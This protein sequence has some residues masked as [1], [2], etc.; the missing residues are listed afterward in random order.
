MEPLKMH[1]RF[2]AAALA[3]AAVVVMPEQAR[4]QLAAPAASPP[5]EAGKRADALYKQGVRLY[6]EKKWA[7]AEAAFREAWALNPTFDVAYNLGSAEY[8]LGKHRDAAEHLALAVRSWPLL[9]A[10]SILR[11]T[12]QQ[13]LD[14]CRAQVG[15]LTVTV[16]VARAE[17]LIDGKSIGR[18]PLEGEVFVTPGVHTVEATFVGHT[19]VPRTLTAGKGAAEVVTLVLSPIVVPPSSPPVPVLPPVRGPSTVLLITGGAVAGLALVSGAIF[20]S[21]S[22]G[23]SSEGADKRAVFVQAGSRPCTSTGVM[24]ATCAD[25][26]DLANARRTFANAA[27]WSFVGAGAVGA[28][29]L[30]YAL[31][32]PRSDTKKGVQVMPVGGPQGAGIEIGGTW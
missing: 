4:A 8:Q 23:K 25:L 22:N 17:V 11:Q 13:R 10:T 21:I 26:A 32:T 3:F 5:P 1:A 27:F 18:A 28:G 2:L 14:E 9:K 29:T 30:I 19:S 24:N 15:T 20:A 12:A 6:S 31:A 16:N 7:D